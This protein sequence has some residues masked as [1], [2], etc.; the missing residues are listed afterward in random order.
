MKK[1]TL[2]VLI[3][4]FTMVFCSA[5]L[6]EMQ[7]VSGGYKY[8]QNGNQL[9]MRDM[10]NIMEPNQQAF[11][12]IKKAQ[13]NQSLASVIGFIGG[14]LVGWPIGTAIGGGDA[15]WALAGVGAALIGVS[16]PISS[17]ANKKA[18]QAVEVYNLSLGATAFMGHK[19]QL[20][21]IANGNGIGLSLGF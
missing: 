4:M 12:F 14:G 20:R 5:Q 16:I 7:K 6:I 18:K 2:T 10:V 21:F 8:S 1:T 17:S 19:T 9:K 3:A 13:S 11:N 15:N